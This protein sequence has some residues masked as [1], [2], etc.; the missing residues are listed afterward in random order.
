MKVRLGKGSEIEKTAR[1]QIGTS[2]PPEDVGVLGAL[3]FENPCSRPESLRLRLQKPIP[4]W[5]PQARTK[6]KT[7]GD[8]K[9]A[10][11]RASNVQ[12]ADVLWSPASSNDL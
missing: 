8:D 11:S 2:R 9:R 4:A 5:D 10:G 7:L 12:D 1:Y 3:D 6:T